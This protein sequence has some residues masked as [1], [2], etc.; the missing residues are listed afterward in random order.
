M[1]RR[2]QASWASL[3]AAEREEMEEAVAMLTEA[4]AQGHMKAQAYLGEIYRLDRGVAQDYG[5]AFELSRQA[6]QQGHAASQYNLGAAYVNGKGCE[7]SDERAAEW[8]A[9]AAE[10]GYASAQSAL[11][12]MYQEGVGVLQSYERA[13]ELFRLSEAQGNAF[14]TNSLGASYQNGFGVDQSYAEARRLY[15]LAVAL[16]ETQVAPSN[17]QGLNDVIQ[18]DCPLLGQRVVLRGLNTAALNGMCGTTVDFGFSKRDPKTG[19]WFTDS[20]RYTVRLDGPEE[21]LVKVRAADTCRG[22]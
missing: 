20:G 22:V 16:G 3:P 8:L 12:L 15:R 10:Q 18:Q 6:A 1:V 4:A 11:G 7:Q 2:G 21:R 9:Q 19:N 5:R 13:I 14:A 17:L